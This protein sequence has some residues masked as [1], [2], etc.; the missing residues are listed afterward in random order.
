MGLTAA[1]LNA[2]QDLPRS[3][4]DKTDTLIAAVIFISRQDPDSYER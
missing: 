4:P 3:A 1:G 2:G